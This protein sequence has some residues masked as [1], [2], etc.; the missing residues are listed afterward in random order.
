MP[1]RYLA[2]TLHLTTSRS[3]CSR[4]PSAVTWT[5]IVPA[6]LCQTECFQ[7]QL[8]VHGTLW[9][10]STATENSTLQDIFWRKFG[11]IRCVQFID[12]YLSSFVH[13]PGRLVLLIVMFI[14]YVNTHSTTESCGMWLS[15]IN[16]PVLPQTLYTGHICTTWLHGRTMMVLCPTICY[17]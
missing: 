3:S 13:C 7:L 12:G 10:L 2:E 9:R 11:R 8:P 15:S 6:T 5:L 4:L 1:S 14:F 17:V 16:M